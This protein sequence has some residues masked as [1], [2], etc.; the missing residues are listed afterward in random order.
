MSSISITTKSLSFKTLKVIHNAT[1]LSCKYV[2]RFT[3]MGGHLSTLLARQGVKI[4][5]NQRPTL[6]SLYKAYRTVSAEALPVLYFWFISRCK[7]EQQCN[8][9]HINRFKKIP[10]SKHRVIIL[11]SLYQC[12]TSD[13]S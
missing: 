6:V 5:Q 11:L 8:M 12:P 10:V 9:Q 2:I 4:L 13:I 7:G 1:Y 3:Y